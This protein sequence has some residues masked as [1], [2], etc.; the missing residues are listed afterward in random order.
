M[1]TTLL[2]ALAITVEVPPTSM[3]ITASSYQTLPPEHSTL[4]TIESLSYIEPVLAPPAGY[5]LA[6]LSLWLGGY[7]QD[8][9]GSGAILNGWH[10]KINGEAVA[11]TS[12]QPKWI[13]VAFPQVGVPAIAS[14]VPSVPEQLGA[15]V[16][17]RVLGGG[18]EVDCQV[19]AIIPPRDCQLREFRSLAY[20]AVYEQEQYWQVSEPPVLALASLLLAAGWITRSKHW[21]P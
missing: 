10:G 20:R 19:S 3:G 21:Q 14:D 16:F 8:I 7:H 15:I 5:E 6:S 2:L 18:D 9:G 12:A 4:Y 1:L 17:G 13:E 11:P